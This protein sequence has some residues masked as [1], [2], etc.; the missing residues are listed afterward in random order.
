MYS[1]RLTDA[2]NMR[3]KNTRAYNNIEIKVIILLID[4]T[5]MNRAAIRVPGLLSV[6]ASGYSKS[7]LE[8]S[9]T[10]SPSGRCTAINGS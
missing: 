1:I 10:F 8:Y 6:I 2:I 4:L 9:P 7:V 5:F 3:L